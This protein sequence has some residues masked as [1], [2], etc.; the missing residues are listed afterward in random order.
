MPV[1]RH[2]SIEGRHGAV[3]PDTHSG[4]VRVFLS[5]ISAILLKYEKSFGLL[6]KSQIRRWVYKEG[7]QEFGEIHLNR[8]Y[9]LLGGDTAYQYAPIEYFSGDFGLVSQKYYCAT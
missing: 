9:K 3:F 4:C 6:Y 5:N 7:T 8:G 1:F 2:I